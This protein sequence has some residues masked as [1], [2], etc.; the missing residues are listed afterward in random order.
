M[1]KEGKQYGSGIDMGSKNWQLNG[2][3]AAPSWAGKI[4][5]LGNE[6]EQLQAAPC[7]QCTGGCLRSRVQQARLPRADACTWRAIARVGCLRNGR[8]CFFSLTGGGHTAL[9]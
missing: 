4:Q 7:R 1:A 9:A 8:G 2:G 3:S 5:V 6:G